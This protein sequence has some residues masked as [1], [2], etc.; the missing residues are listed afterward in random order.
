MTSLK[1]DRVAL[2]THT[3]N[4]GVWAVTRFLWERLQASSR[5]E[6]EIVLLATSVT[7]PH[8]VRLLRPTTWFRKLHPWALQ[9]EDQRCWHIGAM[10]VE[11][12][13]QRYRPRTVLTSFLNGYD[14]VQ[15]V[16]GSPAW[17]AAAARVK[18]P[19]CVFAATTVQQERAALVQQARGWRKLYLRFMNA[20]VTHIEAKALGRVDCVFAESEYTRRLM[21]PHVQ[22]DRLVLG[23]PGVDTDLFCPDGPLREDGYILS[24]GRLSDPRKNVRLLIDAYDLL[25]QQMPGAPRLVL[26]GST[27]PPPDDWEHARTLG[28]VDHIEMRVNL[29]LGE[30]AALYKGATMFVMSSDEEGL[31]MVILEAMA[32]GLPMISTDCGGPATVVLRGKTGLLTPVGDVKA[33]AEAMRHLLTDVPLRRRMGQ[34]GRERAERVFSLDAAGQVYLRKYD[35]LLS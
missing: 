19:T 12:E 33:L 26:A 15:V 6:P 28:L 23:L 13:F 8:S 3:T 11:F 7:D 9:C 34:A 14:L 29:S 21:A 20:V 4:G 5:Y 31:G 18:P 10:F 16:A 2:V 27:A 17:A 25:R 24:V 32:S 22:P 1:P 30:L 35:E